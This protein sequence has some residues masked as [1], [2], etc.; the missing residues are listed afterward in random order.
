[1]NQKKLILKLFALVLGLLLVIMAYNFLSSGSWMGP[2]NSLF[3]PP[4]PTTNWC[5][6][7][8]VD[9]KWASEQVPEQLRQLDMPSLRDDYCELPTEPITGLD[10]DKV[11]WAPLVE[12]A[13]ATGKKTILEW[14][15]D[16][17]LFRAGGL[18]F[19]SSAFAKKLKLQ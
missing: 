7:H 12:S 15:Q 14:N 2:L 11:N 5:A 17:A 9:V 18:P 19:K 10:L 4:E 8:V 1:M 3:G 13:G 6:E 16:L